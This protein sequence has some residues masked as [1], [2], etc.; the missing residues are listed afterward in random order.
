[1]HRENQ[2]PIFKY[3]DS[4][5]KYFGGAPLPQTKGCDWLI[6]CS[7]VVSPVAETL[8]HGD[9]VADKEIT[10]RTVSALTNENNLKFFCN[11]WTVFVC[12]NKKEI[13]QTD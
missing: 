8:R 11:F 3:G 4:G 1:M 10:L 13:V 12:T 5:Q 6:D 7:I 2:G 9:I